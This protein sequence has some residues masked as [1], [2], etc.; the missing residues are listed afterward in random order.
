MEKFKLTLPN[1][2]QADYILVEVTLLH[3]LTG[4]T[5]WKIKIGCLKFHFNSQ[6]V[7]LKSVCTNALQ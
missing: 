6:N 5:S 7:S 3:S 4:N 2:C 1:K